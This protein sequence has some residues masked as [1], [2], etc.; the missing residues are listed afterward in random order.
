MQRSFATCLFVM[1][2]VSADVAL[3]DDLFPPPW[4]GLPFTTYSEWDFLT[5]TNPAPPDG[6]LPIVGDGGGGGPLANMLGNL[7]WDPVFNG[8]WISGFGGGQMHFEIPNW[9]DNRPLKRMQV[10]ITYQQHP[11]FDGINV[12]VANDP[13]GIAGIFED[14]ESDIPLDPLNGLFHRTE[15]WRIF[16]NPDNELLI[17]NVPV[18][19]AITQVV[20]DTWSIPEPTSLLLGALA[21]V[22]LLLWRRVLS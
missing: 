9:I 13:T 3:G 16:P 2:A 20:V 8:S 15:Q 4:R 6:G 22:G 21:S 19:M 5:P 18:D 10:Q 7:F 17:M 14:S 11:L 12:V 1:L